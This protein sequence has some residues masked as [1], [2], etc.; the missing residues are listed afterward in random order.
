MTTFFIFPSVH[1]YIT[2]ECSDSFCIFSVE[3]CAQSV[4]EALDV[5][6][7]GFS[8]NNVI[9]AMLILLQHR[10]HEVEQGFLAEVEEQVPDNM[11]HVVMERSGEKGDQ[12][13]SEQPFKY[14][15]KIFV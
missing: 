4:D 13:V 11:H 12:G 6:V 1:D 8:F 7:R 15:V 10:K 5:A 2:C 14:S 9:E 3:I